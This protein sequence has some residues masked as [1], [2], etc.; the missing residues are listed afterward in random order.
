[1]TFN[2]SIVNRIKTGS[3]KNVQ[4]FGDGMKRPVPP[5]VVIKPIAGGDRKLLQIIV[6]MTIGMQDALEKYVLRELSELLD[7][8]LEADE[9]K[10]TARSTGGWI[11]PY[12]DE[13]DNTISMSRD[14]YIPIIL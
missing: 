3:I 5:Y 6:R 4:M 2:T 7:E 8:P 9:N 10:I 12:T 13:T 14:F 11:G 1:M